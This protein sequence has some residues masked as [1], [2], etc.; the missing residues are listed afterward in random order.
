MDD[1]P[2][3]IKTHL[4][5]IRRLDEKSELLP[6]EEYVRSVETIVPEILARNKLS[7]VEGCSRF[8][9]PVLIDLN[10][11]S[12]REFC[13]API[14]ALKLPKDIDMTGRL[15]ERLSSMFEAGLLQEAKQIFDANLSAAKPIV[16]STVYKPL[17][18]Y[19]KGEIGL[20]QAKDDIVKRGVVA[21]Q[22]GLGLFQKIP[23]VVWIEHDPN[24]KEVALKQIIELIRQ[25]NEV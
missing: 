25:C 6:P 20:D 22:N 16:T 18:R 8:Y 2:S 19:F 13:Y 12:N 15:E 4:F 3:D 11:D 9:N 21:Y 23:E 17:M 7:I 24:K 14:I 10:K 1:Y 5:G